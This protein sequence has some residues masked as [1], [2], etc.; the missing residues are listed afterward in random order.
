[1]SSHTLELRIPM[2]QFGAVF[3]ETV[4][5]LAQNRPSGKTQKAEPLQKISIGGEH[6]GE[7]EFK[8]Q[9]SNYMTGYGKTPTWSAKGEISGTLRNVDYYGDGNKVGIKA[10][11]GGEVSFGFAEIEI[12]FLPIPAL[13]GAVTV[14]PKAG[15]K[16]FTITL[17][18]KCVYDESL[19]DP[20][21]EKLTGSL[22]GSSGISGG[23]DVGVG[24]P[25]YAEVVGEF[26]AGSEITA[27]ADVTTDGKK[28]IILKKFYLKIGVL[29]G[30]V[31]VKGKLAGSLEW[32]AWKKETTLPSDD[33]K[34]FLWEGP[35]EVPLYTIPDSLKQ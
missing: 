6:T 18:L 11:L 9:T 25:K 33:A 34:P 21:A 32:E 24:I 28:K 7:K 3:K 14:T 13:A 10:T 31:A 30:S 5:I 20:W 26:R 29:K 12:P 2:S 17:K 8:T 1:M 15:F 4:I 19:K 23:L 35:E 27:G 22:E 16:K